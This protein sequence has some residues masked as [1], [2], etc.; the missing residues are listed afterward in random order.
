MP[1][2]V[3]ITIENVHDLHNIAGQPNFEAILISVQIFI[4]IS[5]T[6]WDIECTCNT[7]GS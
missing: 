4:S 3:K 5:H 6:V 1:Q 7:H 2:P